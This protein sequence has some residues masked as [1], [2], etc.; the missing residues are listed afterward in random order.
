VWNVPTVG[1]SC[2][3]RDG[4]S[5]LL[6]S[7]TFCI[8]MCSSMSISKW[9]NVSDPVVSNASRTKLCISMLFIHSI[10]PSLLC[11]VNR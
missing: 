6:F 5:V 8:S 7:A 2:F 4:F 10:N 11:G 9:L 3:N 1:T